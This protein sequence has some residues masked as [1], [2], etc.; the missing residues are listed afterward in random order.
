MQWETRMSHSFPT[1]AWKL[2]PH[3]SLW[4]LMRS[5]FPIICFLPLLGS[6]SAR[7]MHSCWLWQ[8]RKMGDSEQR[9]QHLLLWKMALFFINIFARRQS[10]ATAADFLQVYLIKLDMTVC[11]AVGEVMQACGLFNVALWKWTVGTEACAT[12]ISGSLMHF[13]SPTF[14]NAAI[15]YINI[16]EEPLLVEHFSPW[17]MW[18]MLTSFP[19]YYTASLIP[20]TTCCLK[21]NANTL[22]ELLNV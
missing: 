15:L 6:S 17:G 8:C 3:L 9:G 22:S 10:T 2:P 11:T 20:L 4:L 7:Q 18:Q 16:I 13:Y 1:S 12:Q 21:A 14:R 19:V 5:T